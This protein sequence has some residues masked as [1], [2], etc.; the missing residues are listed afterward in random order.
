ML[1]YEFAGGELS[2]SPQGE[3]VI[4]TGES[5]KEGIDLNTHE[6]N[7]G[8]TKQP[9]NKS[10]VDFMRNTA[11]DIFR[12]TPTEKVSDY[13]EVGDQMVPEIRKEVD[14]LFDFVEGAKPSENVARGNEFIEANKQMLFETLELQSSPVLYSPSIA[15]G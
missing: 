11:K 10:S 6:W 5:L 7:K 4:D 9:I 12:E 2:V 15:L 13:L 3:T 1:D 8:G 14:A